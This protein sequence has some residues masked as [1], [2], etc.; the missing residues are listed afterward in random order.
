[1]ACVPAR[2]TASWIPFGSDKSTFGSSATSMVGSPV[3]D[4]YQINCTTLT[5]YPSTAKKALTEHSK[6]VLIQASSC[7]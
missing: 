6:H 4:K 3:V 7:I 2:A 1:M 5:I